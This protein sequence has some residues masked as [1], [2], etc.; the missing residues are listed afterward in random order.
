MK[1]KEIK[2]VLK[3]KQINKNRNQKYKLKKKI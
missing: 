1:I 3:N 2:N